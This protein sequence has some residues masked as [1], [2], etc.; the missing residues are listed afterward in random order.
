MWGWGGG[1]QLFTWKLVK[2]GA[3][4]SV[5][6]L[7]GDRVNPWQQHKRHKQMNSGGSECAACQPCDLSAASA[8]KHFLS[9]APETGHSVIIGLTD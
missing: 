7:F 2:V 9:A 6:L 1:E 4:D 8:V 5:G 3:A